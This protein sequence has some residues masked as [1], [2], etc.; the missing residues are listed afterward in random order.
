MSNAAADGKFELLK[1][2]SQGFEPW[3]QRLPLRGDYVAQQPNQ[4]AAIV[5]GQVEG[6][7]AASVLKQL[8]G[9]S[10]ELGFDIGDHNST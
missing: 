4:R 3:Q 10:F 9:A 2:H 5:L 8:I 7:S 6:H 1:D